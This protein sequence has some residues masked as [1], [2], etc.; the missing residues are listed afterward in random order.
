MTQQEQ[1]KTILTTIEDLAVR[2]LHGDRREDDD[3][4][5]GSVEKAVHG[6]VVTIAQMAARFEQ[7]LRELI[8]KGPGTGEPPE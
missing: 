7:K 2:F 6:Q 1:E 5:P 8:P 3:L 4:P